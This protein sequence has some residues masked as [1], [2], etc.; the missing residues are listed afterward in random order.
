M[1]Y[2]RKKVITALGPSF[3]LRP[4][5]GVFTLMWLNL[6]YPCQIEPNWIETPF[7]WEKIKPFNRHDWKNFVKFMMHFTN[8]FF[9][10]NYS[11]KE[12]LSFANKKETKLLL[13]THETKAQ[14]T[15]L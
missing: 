3:Y 7:Y 1:C 15:K 14:K 11:M 2:E 13:N 8:F 4:K 9:V 5:L 6:I 12:A 10:K